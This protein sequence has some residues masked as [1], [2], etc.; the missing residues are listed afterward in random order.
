MNLNALRTI[1]LAASAAT[2]FAGD[3]FYWSAVAPQPANWND[4]ASWKIGGESQWDP[5]ATVFP[6]AANQDVV[7]FRGFDAAVTANAGA[8]NVFWILK[9]VNGAS[10]TFQPPGVS[11]FEG[12]FAEFDPGCAF[13]VLSGT[14]AMPA[15]EIYAKSP[16]SI[17]F[18]GVGT[19]V[20]G[21]AAGGGN[22][23][24]L[25]IQ[26]FDHD[27]DI[28]F[29][30]GVHASNVRVNLSTFDHS[31][32]DNRLLIDGTGTVIDDLY[33][34]GRYYNS[35]IR[36]EDGATVNGM[37]FKYE[38]NIVPAVA[39]ATNLFHVENATV[40]GLVF[41]WEFAQLPRAAFV[42]GPGSQ[43]FMPA[44]DGHALVSS[45]ALLRV[46]G[47]D[48]VFSN[49]NFRVSSRDARIEVADGATPVS[50]WFRMGCGGADQVGRVSGAD[51][52]WTL[53]PNDM[54]LEGVFIVGE[55]DA[56][57]PGAGNTLFIEDGATV[58]I[59]TNNSFK[60]G[61]LIVR[62]T[63]FL[64]GK[65]PGDDGN[66]VYVRNGAVVDNATWTGVGGTFISSGGDGGDGN[67]FCVSNAVYRGGTGYND[68]WDA[69][70]FVGGMQGSG[71]TFEV[72][73]GGTAS[74][75]GC[76]QL[77]RGGDSGGNVLR[78]RNARLDVAY[79][80]NLVP[81]TLANGPCRVEIGGTNGVVAAQIIDRE[82]FNGVDD[83]LIVSLSIPAEG[84]STTEPF[85]RLGEQPNKFDPALA[86][87]G[88]VLG[89][90]IDRHWAQSGRDR[91]IDLVSLA[92]NPGNPGMAEYILTQFASTVSSED[93]GDC[94]TSV[95]FDAASAAWI[96][97]LTAANPSGT[98]VTIR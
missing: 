7:N 14:F 76:V 9:A 45:N 35:E 64:V 93:L 58:N 30:N 6:S 91:T 70:L 3:N 95:E 32:Y 36:V 97:R 85:L 52:C 59:V 80:I 26:V 84:R 81:A 87:G 90:D 71:N 78:C 39:L 69:T 38:E 33:V 44:W 96:L 24:Y 16:A 51:T 66:A 88:I 5:D 28:R 79:K 72:L 60:N 56:G 42:F 17:R 83:P 19:R 25:Q 47:E 31:G 8:T 48:A 54:E 22:N 49:F 21:R 11:A 15:R 2:A 82:N 18:E 77:A 13:S 34:G 86:T 23:D 75:S 55:L 68:L 43:V 98:L 74:F 41:E 37:K 92:N 53:V 1:L 89:L 27:G 61:Q 73:D 63:G 46:A 40:N 62:L 65:E 57:R 29:R 50:R 94:G 67:L 10:V 12:V 4:L 20:I